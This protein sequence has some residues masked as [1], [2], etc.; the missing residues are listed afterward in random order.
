MS[1]L[2]NLVQKLSTSIIIFRGFFVK[3]DIFVVDF[4]S[5]T[6]CVELV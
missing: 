5:L 3:T 1:F 6:L 4:H 2:Q